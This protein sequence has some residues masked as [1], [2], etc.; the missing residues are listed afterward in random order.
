LKTGLFTLETYYYDGPLIIDQVNVDF[1]IDV[2]QP[3]EKRTYQ[4]T[5]GTPID[6]DFSVEELEEGW[7]LLYT[8]S[9][10]WNFDNHFQASVIFDKSSPKILESPVETSILWGS[11][12]QL[13]WVIE[14]LNGSYQLLLDGEEIQSGQ[15]GGVREIIHNL[16]TSEIRNYSFTLILRDEILNL[17]DMH[18]FP[19]SVVNTPITE[20]GIRLSGNNLIFYGIDDTVDT[21][22]LYSLRV[23]NTVVSGS[24]W[25][26]RLEISFDLSSLELGDG[27]YEI[28]V[29]MDDGLGEIGYS[30]VFPIYIEDGNIYDANNG[31]PEINSVFKIV[32]Y[33]FLG[34]FTV[35]VLSMVVIKFL[36]NK[37]P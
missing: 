32:A 9:Y 3:E 1:Q 14:E 22:S 27:Y 26:S 6:I 5:V 28:T 19:I 12:S 16:D 17:E 13:S 4:G 11:T 20:I 30:E 10:G 7:Y 15:I 23:N 33:S 21:G 29:S 18:T 35:G 34:V 36:R 31:L 25:I 2:S 24:T 8:N 37:K